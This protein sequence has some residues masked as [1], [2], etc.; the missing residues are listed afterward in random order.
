MKVNPLLKKYHLWSMIFLSIFPALELKASFR[1]Q[2]R[3]VAETGKYL[4]FL[5]T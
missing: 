4:G 2:L 1:W 3:E 5:P